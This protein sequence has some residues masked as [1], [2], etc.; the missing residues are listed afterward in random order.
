MSRTRTGWPTTRPASVPNDGFQA[1][2][3]A[4][5]FLEADS[6]ESYVI[7]SRVYWAEYYLTFTAESPLVPESQE[8]RVANP[9]LGDV[10]YA[11]SM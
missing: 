1:P 6:V 9:S 4:V 11:D 8:Y 7:A 10:R 3:F 5:C 2:F